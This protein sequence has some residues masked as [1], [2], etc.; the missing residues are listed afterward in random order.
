MYG[1]CFIP[2]IPL[3][4]SGEV[5]TFPSNNSGTQLFILLVP[6]QLTA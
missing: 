1:N 6:P 3:F 2:S 5:N 4:K